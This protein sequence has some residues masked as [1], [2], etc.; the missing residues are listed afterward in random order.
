MSAFSIPR[1]A[2]LSGA[3]ALPLAGLRPARA[4]EQVTIAT[5][6]GDYAN[7]LRAN[8]DDPLMTPQ[9]VTEV[10]GRIRTGR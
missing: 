10:V 8:V 5:W 3:A 1:R 7:L 2:V 9:G 4:A 6:G